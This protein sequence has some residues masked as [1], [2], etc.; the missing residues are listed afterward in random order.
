MDPEFQKRLLTTYRVEAK[1]HL[2][3]VARDLAA[4]QHADEEQRLPLLRRAFSETHSLKG[5]ARSVSAKVPESV[6]H[7][8]ESVLAEVVASRLP[9]SKEMDLVLNEAVAFL[10]EWH[11][12]EPSGLLSSGSAD[13]G[14]VISK[15]ESLLSRRPG[16]SGKPETPPSG[17][18]PRTPPGE[19]PEEERDAGAAQEVPSPAPAGRTRT[20]PTIRTSV[21]RIDALFGRAE[22]MIEG[23]LEGIHQV[24]EISA[25]CETV[26][27]WSREWQNMQADASR[28]RHR[29][30]GGGDLESGR[31]HSSLLRLLEFADWNAE[32]VA[33]VQRELAE[34]TASARA[35]QTA[36]A[37]RLDVLLDEAK[38]LL[39]QPF[40]TA[41]EGT[42]VSLREA[43]RREGKEVNFDLVGGETEM[44]RRILEEMKAPFLH[45][46][47]N[48]L[49]HGIETPEQRRSAGKSEAGTVLVRVRAR[50]EGKLEVRFQD[51][52]AGIDPDRVK[53]EA[54][55]T[56]LLPPERVDELSREDLL[57]LI[58][59]PEFS[60]RG[61]VSEMSG[62]GMGLYI[63]AEKCADLGGS[64]LVES[65]PGKGTCFIILLPVSLS[66]L[67]AVLVRSGGSRFLLPASQVER[68]AR[69]DRT[70]VRQAGGQASIE[71]GGRTLALVDLA[72]LLG[73]AAETPERETVPAVVVGTVDATFALAVDELLDEQ[74]ILLKSL[75]KQLRRVRHI[76]GASVLGSGEVVPVLSV[77]D[78]AH[79]MSGGHGPSPFLRVSSRPAAKAPRSILVVEDSMTARSLLKHILE[80]AGYRVETV[81]DGAEG[82]AR[83][84]AGQFD[85]ILSDVEMPRM[86]GIDLTRALRQD[87]RTADIPVILLTALASREDREKGL[88][89]GAN[90]YIVKTSFDESNLLD[91]VSDFL[92][93]D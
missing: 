3:A 88:E 68:V 80:G 66:R 7:R 74:E 65:E 62:R 91:T 61:E 90:A 38:E 35:H 52:G 4:A 69:I 8:V 34:L 32:F 75:G 28:I 21:E 58:F 54:V 79:S 51:D 40:A 77:R 55:R 13:A 81:P 50:R 67:R 64:I 22:Q 37:R 15:L 29:L 11:Q 60:T 89:A 85:L 47:R 17:A 19:A 86:T 83:A 45:L 30:A 33:D 39:M 93:D 25:L 42:P 12:G 56:K 14:T 71:L 87:E 84:R 16:T 43:A 27:Q 78:L 46:T 10:L 59:R 9:W 53:R 31:L 48:A 26:H 1:E 44:D 41:L 2:E 23:K 6:C 92:A 5:A 82:L 63:V 49:S 57:Q 73:S 18:A 72:A 76:A 70:A 24:E 20:R 36:R